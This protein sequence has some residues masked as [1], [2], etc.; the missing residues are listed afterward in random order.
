MSY[1]HGGN[2]PGYCQ[3]SHAEMMYAESNLVNEIR[4][5]SSCASNNNLQ[6]VYKDQ[7]KSPTSRSPNSNSSE[8]TARSVAGA[9]CPNALEQDEALFI[10][11]MLM[12]P[13]VS[14]DYRPHART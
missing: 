7:K 4:C 10:C 6:R 5:R 9:V 12:Q 2:L 11:H 13:F 8:R 14:T 1:V 3:H